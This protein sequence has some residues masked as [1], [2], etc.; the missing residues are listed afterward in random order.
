MNKP[1][2]HH[3][4]DYKKIILDYLVVLIPLIIYGLY[5]NGV[6]LYK[7]GYISLIKVIYPVLYPLL[8][9]LIGYFINYIFTKKKEL[10]YNMLY[11]IIIGMTVSFNLN[12]FIFIIILSLIL[13]ACQL[14][15]IK[16]DFNKMCLIRLL[17]V[18]ALL[19]LN[20]Y[21][22]ANP[23]EL[24]DKY[25][26]SYFDVLFGRG[27]SGICI[28]NT[29]IS[30]LAYIYLSFNNFY[31]KDIPLMIIATYTICGLI[32]FAIS[33][34]YKPLLNE[35]TTG[36]LVFASVFIATDS[37]NSPYKKYSKILYSVL[38]GLLSFLFTRLIN[39]HEG[40][41]LA[42]LLVS[43]IINF[44]KINVFNKIRQKN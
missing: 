34:E 16:F 5:K 39:S 25:S 3:E 21:S 1:Y 29:F 31:K 15:E 17:T 30:I 43:F 22:Y 18:I 44:T 8:G 10:N 27:V 36:T 12:I 14:F 23:L 37:I 32:Y 33:N 9:G 42:I 24:S 26:Y 40:I 11:G 28:S 7:E 13:G 6:V 4:I 2:L 41:Y 35:L 38:I 20:K 19:V